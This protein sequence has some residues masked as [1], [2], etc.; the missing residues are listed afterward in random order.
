MHALVYIVATAVV[1]HS[2]N[3]IMALS[4][5]WITISAPKASWGNKVAHTE[6]V[7]VGAFP[8][9]VGIGVTRKF[10]TDFVTKFRNV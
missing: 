4:G 6:P 3:T 5:K 1:F 9:D 2:V 7:T 10:V 8:S